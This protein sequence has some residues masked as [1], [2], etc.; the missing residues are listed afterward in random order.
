MPK[1]RAQYMRKYIQAH[2]QRRRAQLIEMLG[3]GCVRCGTTEDLEF[4]HIDPFTKRF[5]I[6]AD[7]TKSWAEL[8]EE[9]SRCQ[10]LC[11]PCHVAKGAED[12]P[13]VAHGLYRYWYWRCRC[14]VCRAANAAKSARDRARKLARSRADSPAPGTLDL[15]RS[16]VA[17]SAEQPAVNRLAGSSS[18]PPR[19][20]KRDFSMSGRSS[21]GSESDLPAAMPIAEP[22]DQRTSG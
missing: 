11:R 18:L 4:D 5:N 7:L 13:E 12:R 1:T 2:K 22:S 15:D 10:L 17:Q 16:G 6:G 21:S 8:A 3:G 20:I 9:A 14:S 19:A